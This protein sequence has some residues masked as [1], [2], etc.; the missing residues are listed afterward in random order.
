[1]Y[2]IVSHFPR[3]VNRKFYRPETRPPRLAF[4][5]RASPKGVQMRQ[6]FAAFFVLSAKKFS[7]AASGGNY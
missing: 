2:L 7:G 4:F 3:Q 6:V 5:R 1:L